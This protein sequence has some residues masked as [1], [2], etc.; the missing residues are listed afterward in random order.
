MRKLHDTVYIHS[1]RVGISSTCSVMYEV[2][3]Y[4]ALSVRLSG[5]SFINEQTRRTAHARRGAHDT[6]LHGRR[7]VPLDELRKDRHYYAQ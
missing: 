6:D 5:L 1:T 4:T 7:D 2:V 3:I